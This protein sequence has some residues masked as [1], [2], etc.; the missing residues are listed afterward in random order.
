MLNSESPRP[1]VPSLPPGVPELTDTLS[2]RSFTRLGD[3]DDIDGIS[4]GDQ[5]QNDAEGEDNREDA[6]VLPTIPEVLLPIAKEYVSVG[7]LLPCVLL[8]SCGY[9]FATVRMWFR[10]IILSA[11]ADVRCTA[12]GFWQFVFQILNQA[13]CGCF[14]I[15]IQYVLRTLVRSTRIC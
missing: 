9:Y 10:C 2:F 15:R 14:G 6:E 8:I 7:P 12:L 4:N 3:E 13:A 1:Y 5:D 11:T